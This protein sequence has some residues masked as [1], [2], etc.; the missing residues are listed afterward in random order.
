MQSMTQRGTS[1]L[2]VLFQGGGFPFSRGA[3]LALRGRK[4][5]LHT[6]MG[7]VLS[8]FVGALELPPSGTGDSLPSAVSGFRP[9][10]QH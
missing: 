1:D 8:S 6:E 5:G 4:C 10:K 9:E 7:R 3:L 2:L